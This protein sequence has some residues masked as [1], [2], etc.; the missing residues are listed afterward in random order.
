MA[1]IKQDLILSS[2]RLGETSTALGAFGKAAVMIRSL[3]VLRPEKG[4][5]AAMTPAGT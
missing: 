3:N 2:A 1:F 4:A 5:S